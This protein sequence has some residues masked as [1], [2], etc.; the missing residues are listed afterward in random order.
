MN[1]AE[2]G[3]GN[4][5]S[6]VVLGAGASRG[7]AFASDGRV[8]PPLD[9]DF[10]EQVRRMPEGSLMARDREL[11]QYVGAEF[12]LGED[13]TLETLFTQVSAIVRCR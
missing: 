8:A 2:L 1:L 7:A 9:A 11:L 4:P 13:P 5:R 3:L 12:G 10:F 6:V